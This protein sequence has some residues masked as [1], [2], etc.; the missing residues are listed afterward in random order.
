M[1]CALHAYSLW[2]SVLLTLYSLRC[3]PYAAYPF[4]EFLRSPPSLCL[5]RPALF[6]SAQRVLNSIEPLLF[7]DSMH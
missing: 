7:E 6:G 1:P 5:L 3:T 4:I 2:N